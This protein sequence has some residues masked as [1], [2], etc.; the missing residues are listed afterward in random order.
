MGTH[1]SSSSNRSRDCNAQRTQLLERLC[2]LLGDRLLPP[3]ALL[4]EPGVSDLERGRLPAGLRER[5]R[6]GLLRLGDSFLPAPTTPPLG[7]GDHRLLLPYRE[8]PFLLGGEA[9]HPPYPLRGG[10]RLR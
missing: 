9:L 2:D 7:G 5:E 10:D 4:L 1:T 3:P 6:D 8:G